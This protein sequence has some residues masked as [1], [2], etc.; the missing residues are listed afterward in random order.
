MREEFMGDKEQNE[1][2]TSI[3]EFYSEIFPYNPAQL[4]FVRRNFRD[5]AEKQILDIG[6]ATGE[7]AFKLAES[8][9][10]VTG[11]DL[12]KDL[13]SKAFQRKLA[14]N[15]EFREG[16]MLELEKNF[17]AASFDGVLCFGNTL[18]HLPSIELVGQVIKSVFKILKPGGKFLLQI[19]NY[20]YIAGEKVSSLPVIDTEDFTFIRKY[21]F[22]KDNPLF[23]FKTDLILKRNYQLISN[24]T[25]LL[26]LKSMDL[27][28]L[29]KKVGFTETE[30][31]S[32][33]KGTPLGG[34]HLPLV[35]SCQK[36]KTF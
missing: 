19:L 7:L 16:D 36:P 22:E 27:K 9:A 35:G 18:V 23:R 5:L 3:S 11:I 4:E 20:D 12:N 34:K 15:P 29:L 26:A 32:D 31:Y 24:E 30:F 13:L 1:F 10:N 17:P 8:G 2:Y 14:T 25:W 28:K 6:C 21:E 33:F